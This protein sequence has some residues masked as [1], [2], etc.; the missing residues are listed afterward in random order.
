MC[1]A[2]LTKDLNKKHCKKYHINMQMEVIQNNIYETDPPY[3]EM[4]KNFEKVESV[5]VP[6]PSQSIYCGKMKHSGKHWK[7]RF[8]DRFG[9]LGFYLL[10]TVILLVGSF[11]VYYFAF[12]GKFL[13]P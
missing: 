8:L 9:Y 2:V 7:K 5:E 13:F 10:I 6:A 11:L 12:Y 1:P 4:K 3:R